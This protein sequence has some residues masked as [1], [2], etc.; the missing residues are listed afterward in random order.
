V[1]WIGSFSAPNRQ[2][3][4]LPSGIDTNEHKLA[5]P[6]TIKLAA[7]LEQKNLRR[8]FNSTGRAALES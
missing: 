1:T 2:A 4:H 8:N 5:T 3:P 6:L 7:S